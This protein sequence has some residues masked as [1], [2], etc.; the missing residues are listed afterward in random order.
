MNDSAGI[1]VSLQRIIHL[2][3]SS[4]CLVEEIEDNASAEFPLLLIVVH[5]QD[6]LECGAVYLVAGLRKEGHGI[7]LLTK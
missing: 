4:L 7:I 1:Y 6:L 2:Y 5:L 3:E